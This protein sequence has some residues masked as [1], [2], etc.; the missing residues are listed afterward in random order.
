MMVWRGGRLRRF[1]GL[2][3]FGALA[4]VLVC[5]NP[6]NAHPLGNFTI[7]HL[8]KVR[9]STNEIDLKYVLDIAE[10]P[11]FQ[12][13]HEHAIDGPQRDALL[14]RWADDEGAIVA[15]NLDVEH[16]GVRARLQLKTPRVSL[17]PG[18]GG[19]PTLY[20]VGEFRAPLP[21][22][23][24]V[25]RI[26][27]RDNVNPE[28]IGWRDI[29]VEPQQEP[30]NELRSYPS[31]LIGSPRHVAATTITTDAAGRVRAVVT[32]VAPDVAPAGTTSQLRS[33]ALSDMLAKGVSNPWV[34][35]VT[36]LMAVGLG[37][38]HALEPGHGKTLLAVSLV[39][40]RATPAQALI[41]A[42]GL[43]FAHTAGVLALGVL[44]MAAAQWIVPEE[45]YPWITVASGVLVAVLGAR[46]LSRYV[47]ERRGEAH[48]HD[49]AGAH[50]HAHGH[51]HA[52][53]H[54]PHGAAPLSFASVVA[55][56]M[57]GN[58][59]PCPAALVVLLAALAL[60]QGAYGL[61]VIV[62]FSLGLAGVLT[63]IGVALV[64]GAAWFST[65][66]RYEAVVAYGPL[67]SAAVI[68]IVGALMLGQGAGA[69]MLHL[70]SAAITA[71][72]LTAIAGFALAPGHAHGHGHRHHATLDGG[73]T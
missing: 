13:M 66:P 72:V 53:D 69:S 73:L 70:P 30:T 64:R 71:L 22:A 46:A 35:L 44:L 4:A 57:S 16:D 49:H 56:A 60:H 36:L 55:V 26:V 32:D 14:R 3:I 28:R 7:N 17:R 48:R 33:N 63:G 59:A 40:A 8:T 43:T 34:V 39:G 68:A 41:L 21:P 52:H 31:A 18:A 10:I 2:H 9:V 47:R 5:C 12:I 37:A 51:S 6:A 24:S 1:L 62:A 29:V 15:N 38:L 27:V 11:T 45:I 25:R 65:Q 50:D 20:W 42:A 23:T 58:V 54:V 67:V 61:L 19:L